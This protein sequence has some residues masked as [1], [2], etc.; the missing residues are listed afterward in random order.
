M[1]TAR[2]GAYGTRSAF[3][4]FLAYYYPFTATGT[5]VFVAGAVFLATGLSQADVYRA[6]LGMLALFIPALLGVLARV[7]AGRFT[8]VAVGWDDPADATY[9]TFGGGDLPRVSVTAGAIRPWFFFRL[10]A[11]IRGMLY[12]GEHCRFHVFED[13]ASPNPRHMEVP[14]NLPLPGRLDARRSVQIRDV[15]ALARGAFGDDIRR[16]LEIES[17]M[18]F[19]PHLTRMV[20]A[21]GEKES[22]R[23]TSAEEERYYMREYIPGDRFRDINWKATSRIRELVTR[24]SPQ[25]QDR[26][27]TMT[28]YLRHFAPP[29]SETVESIAHL[30]Y[31]KGW[32][33][34]FMRALLREEA[35]IRFRVI[36]ARGV[37][38]IEDEDGTSQF[39]RSVSTLAYEPAPAHLERDPAARMVIVFSGPFDDQLGAFCEQ[40]APV[41]CRLF[42]TQFPGRSS[43]AGQHSYDTLN[44]TGS[45]SALPASSVR[46]KAK[47]E[48]R[49]VSVP[50]GVTLLEEVELHPIRSR[51]ELAVS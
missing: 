19:G 5:A 33:V 16:P 28:I 50:A 6:S 48:R 47:G 36:T 35:G 37:S 2:A 40:T 38:D 15:F 42:C 29:G 46:F 51:R 18:P 10:H 41:E 31:L 3:L 32:T 30:A 20:A 17:P 26:D 13:I 22:L 34:A 11:R 44:L 8:D 9:R 45:A 14:I 23:S 1:S 21:S 39:S 27:R 7:Q 49:A 43:G 25:T 24:I 12:A 4:K